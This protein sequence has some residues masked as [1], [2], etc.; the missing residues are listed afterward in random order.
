MDNRSPAPVISRSQSLAVE[1]ALDTLPR[2]VVALG[3]PGAGDVLAVLLADP[4]SARL[5]GA[6][7]C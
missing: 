3:E 5:F 2:P 4:I 6:G 7:G 1:D